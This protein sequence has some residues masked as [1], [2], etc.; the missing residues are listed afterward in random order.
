[1]FLQ[2]VEGA[3]LAFI[4]FTEAISK[5]PGSPI[6]SVLFF[7]ML[8]CLGLSTMFGNIEGVVVPLKDL[9]VF[10]K[11]WP[12]EALTGNLVLKIT[13]VNSSAFHLPVC[14]LTQA[15]LVLCICVSGITC[16]VAFIITLLFAQRSGLYW[17]TLF[18]N[19]AGSIPL[20]T[21]GFFEMIA[22]VYI[23]GIDRFVHK[24]NVFT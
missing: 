17:V 20:L 22:V 13:S 12:Q 3:G 19:F 8:L 10:P 1:M 4:V 11:K 2:G 18:D 14:V 23:Y 21:I 6:W 16:F 15:P 24:V 9:N 7:I 5:M